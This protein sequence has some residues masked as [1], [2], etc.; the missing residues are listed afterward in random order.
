MCP[1][2]AVF[3]TRVYCDK[4]RDFTPTTSPMVVKRKKGSNF[5]L[6]AVCGSCNSVKPFKHLN[7]RQV[8][9]FPEEIRNMP[10]NSEIAVAEPPAALNE[11]NAAKSS[12]EISLNDKIIDAIELLEEHGFTVLVR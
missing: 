9:C 10:E 7:M 1:R 3:E 11:D 5:Y 8:I 2:K 4:C 12:G 6:R